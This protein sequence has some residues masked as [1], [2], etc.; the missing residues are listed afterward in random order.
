MDDELRTIGGAGQRAF[1]IQNLPSTLQ[2][3]IQQSLIIIEPIKAGLS[4][5]DKDWLKLARS[6]PWNRNYGSP[7]VD[8]SL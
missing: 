6:V 8:K 1:S 2:C 7:K 5:L 3:A 4:F